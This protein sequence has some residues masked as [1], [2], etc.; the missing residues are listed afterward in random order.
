MCTIC[1]CESAQA[2]APHDH[3]H[4]H[5]HG[6]SHAHDAAA[7]R[8]GNG[9]V[10]TRV[11]QLEQDILAGNQHMADHV[12]AHLAAQHTL[13]LNLVSSP[14][15]GK[16]T[17][18]VETVA[19][20]KAQQRPVAVI[21]GDQQ[22]SFDAER[23][24]ATGVQAVQI[25][26]GK[27]CHLDAR[28]VHDA[29]HDLPA[30]PHGVLMIENVGNL[31]CPAG[32]DLGERAKVLVFSVTEGEDKPLKYPDMFQAAGLILLHK[33][34]LLPHVRFDVARALDF[35][36]QVNPDA[37]VIQLSSTTGEGFDAWMAWIDAQC[38]AA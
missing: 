36:R 20:L 2:H 24:R 10:H 11:L 12:R 21:E 30:L 38:A 15:S 14:G 28:M 22:T 9:D 8:P 23:I 3:G 29:L 4:A 17:L 35:V 16:T 1:G 26:T 34:D 5:S 6:H 32:F 19:R 7:S 18:L 13:A 37:L 25:N 33:C 31:V 27:G